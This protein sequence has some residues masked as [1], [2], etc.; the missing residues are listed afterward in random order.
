TYRY[1]LTEVGHLGQNF[2]L[3]ATALG[4]GVCCIGALFDD[5]LHQLLDIDGQEE[6]AL[7]LITVGAIA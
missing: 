3:A 1:V 4:L 7:Y 2:Y 5:P 6:A